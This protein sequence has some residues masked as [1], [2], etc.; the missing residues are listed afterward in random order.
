[1]HI[2]ISYDLSDTENGARN[3]DFNKIKEF[4]ERKGIEIGNTC[5]ILDIGNSN[6]ESYI[7]ILEYQIRSVINC[8]DE[9]EFYMTYIKNSDLVYKRII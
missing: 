4:F 7:P 2:G 9:D 8:H 6:P 1:M 3:D 5:Y